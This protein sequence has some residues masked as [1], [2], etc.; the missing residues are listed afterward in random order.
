MK[1]PQ[2]IKALL[3]FAKKSRQLFAGEKVVENCLKTNRA[4]LIL[5]ATDFSEKRKRF[6]IEWCAE[7]RVPSFLLGTKEEYGKILGTTP[8]SL[9]AIIDKKMAEEICKYLS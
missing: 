3:G 9:L 7:K 8:R 2:K 5:I 1:I 6:F 4:Q